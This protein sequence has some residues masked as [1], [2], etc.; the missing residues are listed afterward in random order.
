MN[1]N[2]FEAVGQKPE[3][4]S[5][6]AAKQSA[7][8]FSTE[9]QTT[10]EE[11]NQKLETITLALSTELNNKVEMLNALEEK[12]EL[13]NLQDIIDG[14]FEP[15]LQTEA[16]AKVEQQA[17]ME[18]TR[19]SASTYGVINSSVVH[20]MIS[21]S[22]VSTK[23]YPQIYSVLDTLTS[24]T[25]DVAS[26]DLIQGASTKANE[27]VSTINSI[28]RLDRVFEN[29]TNKVSNRVQK[30]QKRLQTSER[31]LAK[32][33]E[34]LKTAIVSLVAQ[35]DDVLDNLYDTC[36]YGMALEKMAKRE[37]QT[38]T[39]LQVQ[40][41]A[42]P[43]EKRF[44]ISAQLQEQ[45]DIVKLSTKRLIDLKAFALKSMGLYNLF[46]ASISAAHVIQ[47]E[48]I[49]AQTNVM[50]SLAT[51]LHFLNN[52]LYTL[53]VAKSTQN[54]RNAELEASRQ[55]ANTTDMVQTVAENIL[56]DLSTTLESVSIT[57]EAAIATLTAGKENVNKVVAMQKES[58]HK[59]V[60]MVQKLGTV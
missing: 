46:N 48:L 24:T 15:Q 11:S 29:F 38:L 3:F 21:E 30:Y 58:E 16:L 37:M 12:S 4:E 19:E 42:L 47:S 10:L 33:R 50:Y 20:A 5:P 32:Q 56:T 39:E 60:E 43:V 8:K 54:L 41:D 51:Q 52:N 22:D 31:N 35:R 49:F 1:E 26:D 36:I 25:M 34:E 9:A 27:I 14:W 59:M 53:R 17:K 57:I 28:K 55:L 45:Q 7:Q 13:F 6:Q 44:Q 18:L 23:S 40:H 2:P